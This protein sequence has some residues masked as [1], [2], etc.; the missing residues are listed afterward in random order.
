MAPSKHPS[1]RLPVLVTIESSEEIGRTAL[2]PGHCSP[3]SNI[4]SSFRV[5]VG[6][7]PPLSLFLI[8]PL[9]R[10]RARLSVALPILVC[11]R[12]CMQQKTSFSCSLAARRRPAVPKRNTKVEHG[13]AP[14]SSSRSRRASSSAARWVLPPMAR[15]SHSHSHLRPCT[16]TVTLEALRFRICT[17]AQGTS[18]LQPSLPALSTSGWRYHPR[19]SC[20][21][22]PAIPERGP[23]QACMHASQTRKQPPVGKAHGQKR[24]TQPAGCR[25]RSRP[26]ESCAVPLRCYVC[27]SYSKWL[28]YKY[29]RVGALAQRS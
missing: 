23:E 5:S 13:G 29:A 4:R 11:E 3:K 19:L 1:P 15:A 20:S 28:E 21:A 10:D 27:T 22:S 26:S 16:P 7:T 14:P 8:L 25:R 9:F 18:A 6:P 12:A 24:H 17:P 2:A